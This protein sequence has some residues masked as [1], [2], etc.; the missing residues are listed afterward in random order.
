MKKK[1]SLDQKDHIKEMH[2]CT[3]LMVKTLDSL[4]GLKNNITEGYTELYDINQS[5]T[6][7]RNALCSL[8][9]AM[10]TVW[11]FD[12]DSKKHTWW[13]K[14]ERCTCPKLD[15]MDP[16]Y[17]GSGAIIN[18]DC[19]IHGDI[20]GYASRLRDIAAMGDHIRPMY[21]ILNH[22]SWVSSKCLKGWFSDSRIH[23]EDIPKWAHKT[24]LRHTDDDDSIPATAEPSVGVNFFG[25]FI[26]EGDPIVY[27]AEDNYVNVVDWWFENE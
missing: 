14:P 9:Y 27:P 2:K 12:R 4:A 19:P 26:Y 25:D 15:N 23:D 24:S 5:I 22:K 20:N 17:Y 1:L 7:T 21:L 6:S 18:E 11:G 13:L 10:Q 8:E 3:T 16:A